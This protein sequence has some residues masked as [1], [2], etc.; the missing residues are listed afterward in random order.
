MNWSLS[1][2]LHPPKVIELIDS[3]TRTLIDE[4][5]IKVITG[6]YLFDMD[7]VLY[8][9]EIRRLPGKKLVVVTENHTFEALESDIK[10]Y[11]RV[12]IE[13]SKR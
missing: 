5:D 13:M 8:L 7:D 10:V 1:F 6:T 11:G 2:C 4:E 3:K 12:A 9:V